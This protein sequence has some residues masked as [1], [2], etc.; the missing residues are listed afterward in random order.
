[1]KTVT[2][3]NLGT[4]WSDYRSPSAPY[5]PTPPTGAPI[6]VPNTQ[7]GGPPFTVVTPTL[8]A[9]LQATVPGDVVVIAAPPPSALINRVNVNYHFE[10][11]PPP[12]PKT[13]RAT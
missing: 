5:V 2:A 10:N 4:T 11:Q 6:Q 13:K 1:M 9:S 8:P 12:P 7:P 3:S